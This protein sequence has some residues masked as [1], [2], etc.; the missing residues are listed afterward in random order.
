MENIRRAVERARA[1]HGSFSSEILQ[2]SSAPFPQHISPPAVSRAGAELQT[3][4]ATLDLAYLASRRIVSHNGADQ[5]SRLYD[6]L[7][8][9]VLQ[10]M[11]AK[12]WKILGV[13]SPTPGCGKTLTAVNLAFSFARQPD[14]SVALIDMD[15]QKPQLASCLGVKLATGGLLDLLQGRAALPNVAIPVNAANQRI[16]VL[17]TV[18]ARQSSELMSSHAM[19]KLLQDLRRDYQIVVLDLPPMLLSDDVIALAPQLDCVLLVAA[20]GLSKAAEVQGCIRHL[21]PS[22][23]LRVVV[24]KATEAN[25]PYSYY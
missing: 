17:P 11:T 9:Q 20:V 4:E 22:R 16:V 7:R 5:R 18:A 8:T 1:G 15:L 13:T 21:E 24:N 2:S 3:E 25:L 23:L 12:K 19:L 10:S 6:V 14:I